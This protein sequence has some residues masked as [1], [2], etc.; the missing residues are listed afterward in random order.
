M[1]KNIELLESLEHPNVIKFFGACSSQEPNSYNLIFE[2]APLGRFDKYLRSRGKK[3]SM[4]KILKICYQVSLALEYLLTKNIIHQNIALRKVLLIDEHN[5]K[6]SDFKFSRKLNEH[7]FYEIVTQNKWPVK[8][9]SPETNSLHLSDEKSEIWSFGVLSWEA[10]SYGE[11]PYKEIENSSVLLYKLENEHFRLA[12]PPNCP[13][14]IFKIISECWNGDMR[15]RPSFSKLVKEISL[16]IYDI[17]HIS[18][19]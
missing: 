6:L 10:T 11:I 8:W 7:F 9:Y 5:S 16:A 2:L 17:Y 15:E 14:N 19:T 12:K 13:E 1:Q 3:M 4:I 18:V